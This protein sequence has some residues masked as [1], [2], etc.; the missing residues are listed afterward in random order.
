MCKGYGYSVD[1]KARETITMRYK[2][3]MEA[4]NRRFLELHKRRCSQFV[5]RFIWS[6]HGNQY[7]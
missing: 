6:R 3:I 4:V 5:R 2:R 7:Q 1:A